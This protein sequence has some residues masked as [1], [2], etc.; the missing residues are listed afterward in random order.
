MCF[1]DLTQ[2]HRKS[3][4]LPAVVVYFHHYA[5]KETNKGVMSHFTAGVFSV[6]LGQSVSVGGDFLSE[7]HVCEWINVE[8]H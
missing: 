8:L 2:F 1:F 3:K 5:V 4:L 7:H 6:S